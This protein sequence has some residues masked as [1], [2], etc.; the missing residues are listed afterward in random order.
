M[1][2]VVIVLFLG[3]TALYYLVKTIDLSFMRSR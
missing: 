2:D 3:I 1:S